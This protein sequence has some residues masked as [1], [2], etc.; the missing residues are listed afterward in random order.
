MTPRHGFTMLEVLLVMAVIIILAGMVYPSIETMYGNA[1]LTA[2]ADQIRARW[3]DAR[4]QAIEECRAYRFAIQADGRFRIA[5]DS[6]R[7]WPNNPTAPDDPDDPDVQEIEIIETLPEGVKFAEGL[8]GEDGDGEWQTVVR[9]LADGSASLDVEITFQ[10][11]VTKPLHLRLR[12]L[13]GA[14]SV[15]WGEAGVQ[16]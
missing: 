14:V 5:P 7:Y 10:A 13:T 12:G 16:R 2:A 8:G 3:A 1:R 9:F 4:T 11:G 6:S 15:V